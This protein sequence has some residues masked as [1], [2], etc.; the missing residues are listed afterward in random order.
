MVAGNATKQ[1]LSSPWL[2]HLMA[3]TL[4][5]AGLSGC[6]P[7]APMSRIPGHYTFAKSAW[8]SELD[9]HSDG[10]FHQ[11]VTDPL[12]HV[13]AT[14]GKWHATPGQAYPLW[15]DGTLPVSAMDKT[16]SSVTFW[17]PEADILWG[18]VCLLVD[19]DKDWYFCKS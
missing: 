10:T 5:A 16:N 1:Q 8:A 4:A 11:V 15:F 17:T 6:Y 13:K 3:L 12:G 19:G 14:N 9:I 2:T 7:G 18:R